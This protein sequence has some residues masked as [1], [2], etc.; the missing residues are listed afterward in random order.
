MAIKTVTFDAPD[1]RLK[2][3]VRTNDNRQKPYKLVFVRLLNL[4]I[5][6]IS[7]GNSFRYRF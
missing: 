6:H 2:C 4:L 3:K 1:T 7:F 5:R